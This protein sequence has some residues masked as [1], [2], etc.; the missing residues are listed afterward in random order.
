MCRLVWTVIDFPFTRETRTE[1]DKSGLPSKKSNDLQLGNE[2]DAEG[3][4]LWCGNSVLGLMFLGLRPG[5]SQA[6]T[7][8]STA[9]CRIFP[10]A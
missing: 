2:C 6:L 4:T 10:L 5:I 3:V 7:D 1:A 9:G 8:T